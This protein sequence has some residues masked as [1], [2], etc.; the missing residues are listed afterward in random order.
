MAVQK[1]NQ[2]IVRMLLSAGAKMHLD[3][4]LEIASAKRDE[5]IVQLLKD[6]GAVEH[7]EGFGIEELVEKSWY[8][9]AM[10][11][12]M[13]AVAGAKIIEERPV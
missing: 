9:S 6:F 3:E 13:Q 4:A 5:E 2:D 1:S 10:D 11:E 12:E 8:Q 7:D